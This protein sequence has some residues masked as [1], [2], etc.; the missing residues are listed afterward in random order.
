LDPEPAVA[1][2]AAQFLRFEVS[3]MRL[4][5]VVG[6]MAAAMAV[7]VPTLPAAAS[8]APQIDAMAFV[9]A[10]KGWVAI[11][12]RTRA[13]LVETTNGGRTWVERSLPP[14]QPAGWLRLVALHFTGTGSGQALMLVMAGACQATFQAYTTTDGGAIWRSRGTLLGSDGPTAV[15]G[16]VFDGSCAT[17]GVGIFRQVGA[18]WRSLRSI[19][20]G[21][22]H[23][24]APPQV[25]GLSGS[26]RNPLVSIAYGIP[27]GRRLHPY[28]ELYRR[29][30]GAWRAV[31]VPVG[32]LAF[33]KMSGILFTSLA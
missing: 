12:G 20:W 16:E 26:E 21:P 2:L 27:K 19:V 1:V 13:W 14:V 23:A 3:D 31:A 17:S 11:E 5:D 4:V 18:D 29:K 6:V 8:F 32:E 9:S 30:A 10:T 33:V 25:L 24:S 15:D 22:G 7:S 28:I